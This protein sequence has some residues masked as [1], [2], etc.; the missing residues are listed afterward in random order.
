MNTE[1]TLDAVDDTPEKALD[2]FP[3]SLDGFSNTLYQS[4]NQR[5]TGLQELWHAFNDCLDNHDDQ[6]RNHLHDFQNHGRKVLRYHGNALKY[7]SYDGWNV[8]TECLHNC[9]DNLQ[10]TLH[11]R[12]KHLWNRLYNAEKQRLSSLNDTR[13]CRCQTIDDSCDDDRKRCDNRLKDGR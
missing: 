1:E 8:F 5:P 6:F 10:Y 11:Y 7:S 4:L 2:R 12:G 9:K 3:Q 13:K